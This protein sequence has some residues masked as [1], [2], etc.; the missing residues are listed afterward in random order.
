MFGIFPNCLDNASNRPCASVGALSF[1][2]GFTTLIASALLCFLL[3]SKRSMLRKLPGGSI[4]TALRARN[5]VIIR[6]SDNY[7]HAN[8]KYAFRRTGRAPQLGAATPAYPR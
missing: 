3:R 1:V 4:I 5:N 2:S 8:V 7:V 6:F